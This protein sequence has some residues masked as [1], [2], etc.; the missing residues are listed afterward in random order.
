MTKRIAAAAVLFLLGAAMQSHATN[1]DNLIGIG[2]VSRGMGGVGVASPQDSLTAI[3][4]NPA[5]MSFCPCGAKSETIFGATAFSPTVKAKIGAPGGTM[6]GESQ[7]DVFPIPAMGVT[8]AINE[9]WRFGIGAYGISGMGVDYRNMG[10][11]LDGNPANGFEGD[12]YSRLEVMKFAPMVSYQINENFSV[13]GALQVAYNNLDLGAGG[14]HDYAY[15]IQLGA[16][17]GTGPFQFGLSWVSPQKATFDRV[18]NFDAFMGDTSFDT[19]ELE[20]PNTLAA[21]VS[22]EPNKQWLVELDVRWYDW[23]GA[24]GY[25]DFDWKDQW[26]FALGGQYRPSEKW[27][28][29]LGYNYGE[30]PVEEHNGFDPM[31]VSTMQGTAVPTLG[32]EMFRIIGFPAVVENHVSLGGGYLIAEDLWLNLSYM[33]A[34]EKTISETSAGGVFALESKLSE[35][36]LSFSLNWAF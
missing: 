34:F 15:G 12:L 2:P 18:F 30:N 29:R 35:D 19:L 23:S 33:H 16:L 25:G 24:D 10:W 31:G 8:M 14:T 36:T 6:S 3:F 13:G 5:G 7:H 21:G 17:Y 27:V 26:V 4:V 9:Q 1:G 22:Y 28:L 32:Y 11:D 20:A